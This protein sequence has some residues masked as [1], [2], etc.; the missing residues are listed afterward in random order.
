MNA[1]DLGTLASQFRDRVACAGKDWR[2]VLRTI[3]ELGGVRGGDLRGDD[4]WTF[5]DGS[6]AWIRGLSFVAGGLSRRS[7][8]TSPVVDLDSPE[9]PLFR[10]NVVEA[11]GRLEFV[12]ARTMPEVPHEYTLRLNTSRDAD[13]AALYDCIMRDGV[14]AFW[15]GKDWVKK[16][17]PARYLCP[18]DGWWYWSMSPRRTV[19]PYEEGRHPLFVSHHINRCTL[20]SWDMFVRRGWAFTN[21]EENG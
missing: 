9:P 2:F 12:F 21:P 1:V 16:C 18:G 10:G 7:E 4:R 13:Y 20:E 19:K 14:I 3:R 5:P 15:R 6:A 8:T 17:R 11:I